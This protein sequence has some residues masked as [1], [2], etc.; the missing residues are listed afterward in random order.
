MKTGKTSSP[1]TRFLSLKWQAVLLVSIVL[2]AVN[3]A[4]SLLSYHSLSDQFEHER[5]VAQQR[6]AQQLS[7]LIKQ[8]EQKLQQLGDMLP[9]FDGIKAALAKGDADLI[10]NQLEKHWPTL[11]IDL[12][13]DSVAFYGNGNQLITYKNTK[14]QTPIKQS[15]SELV[16][17]ANDRET[18]AALLNCNHGCLQYVAVP[19][20][21]DGKKVGVVTLGISLADLLLGFQQ[22]ANADIA[23]INTVAPQQGSPAEEP[24]DRAIPAWGRHVEALTHAEK[25]LRIIR[26]AAKKYPALSSAQFRIR[27]PASDQHYEIA[28]IPLAAYTQSQPTDIAIIANISG[29]LKQIHSA[30]QQSVIIGIISLAL[31]EL[32][33]LAL[34]WVPMARLRNMAETLPLLARSAY[35]KARHAIARPAERQWLADEIDLLGDSTI[36]LSHQ[37][38]DLENQVEHH[39]HSLAEK[40]GEL[41]HERD[42]VQDLLNTVQVII[43]TQ[44]SEG[45]ILLINDYGQRLIG[46]SQQELHGR[47][48]TELLADDGALSTCRIKVEE[49]ISGRQTQTQQ[50]CVI[51]CK[52]GT[53]RNIAWFHSHL[54]SEQ[55][56]GQTL[57]SAGLDITT[58]KQAE[59]RLA[60]LADHDP[61]TMLPNRRRLQEELAIMLTLADRHKHTGALLFIDLD[62]FK[63][64][65]D[66]SGH[67][68]GDA[69]LREVATTLKQLLRSSDIVARLGGDEFAVIVPEINEKGAVQVAQKIHEDLA[70]IEFPVHQRAHKVTAS[71]GIA[72]FPA[73]GAQPHTLLA[74]AD[75]AMYHAKGAGRNRSHLF[76]PDEK[77][78]ER[79]QADIDWQQRIE[80]ALNHGGFTLLYQPIMDLSKENISHYEVLLRMRDKNSA[81]LAPQSFIEVAERNGQIRAIDHFVLKRAITQ[82]SKITTKRNDVTLSINLSAH[83]FDDP[84]LLSLLKGLL[85]ETSVPPKQLVFEITETAALADI[86]AA[87]DLM[88][89]IRRLG[90]QFALDDFGVGFSSFH[91]LK[92]LPFDYVKIDGSFIRNLSQNRDDQILVKGIC[93]VAEGF[94]KKIIAEF[95]E[96]E[97]TLELLREFQVDLAQGYHIGAPIDTVPD[98]NRY[99]TIH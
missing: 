16:K 77:A 79:M 13:I 27:D 47:R 93:S 59:S 38:E 45:R 67:H 99:P 94:G 80:H 65:N 95:V 35:A 82:L 68:A 7:G 92:E 32:V 51:T 52:N 55:K 97:E 15:L 6:H 1:T 21:I 83:A 31:S 8:S 78:R 62:Q 43:L 40:I 72:M 20:L 37:L 56:R 53:C 18:P 39:T 98:D 48:F 49:V 69:L 54:T 89:A 3:V 46:Y 22:I 75:L 19:L 76:S 24:V 26:L 96:N 90:C 33:L 30:V 29:A 5:T 57:L 74:N 86:I 73:H 63:Y 66:T 28:L 4:I 71:I 85:E 91:Y 36:E 41:A 70:T 14:R 42:F 34:L 44:D 58:R 60:W 2:V 81:L 10:S 11:H 50:E 23:I 87:R 25:T 9:T 84:E 61:L 12:G 17:A 64:V 88:I